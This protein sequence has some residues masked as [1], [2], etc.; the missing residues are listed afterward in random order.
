MKKDHL[1]LK[2]FN[3][4][5]R[6]PSGAK[7]Q[8]LWASNFRG[9]GV[10]L[11][12][13]KKSIIYKFKSPITGKFRVIVM[14]SFSYKQIL[15]EGHID[16]IVSDH[17]KIKDKIRAGID[18]LAEK[19]NIRAERKEAELKAK[20]DQEEK[21][22]QEK[23]NKYTLNRAFDS[24]TGHR[25]FTREISEG[26]QIAYMTVYNNHIAPVLG[27]MPLSEIEPYQINNFLDG[28]ED[29]PCNMAICALKRI[30]KV[31]I[32]S[33]KIIKPFIFDVDRRTIGKRTRM[34]K[35]LPVFIAWL[36]DN[37]EYQSYKNGLH[38]Q[39]LYGTRAMEIFGL[40][41]GEID[42]DNQIINISWE[43]VKNRRVAKKQ[44]EPLTLP[45]MPAMEAILKQQKGLSNTYVFPMLTKDHAMNN[46]Q[47][48][49]LLN[50]S[51]FE[52]SSH[53]VRRTVASL[54]RTELM[55]S[56]D[57][58]DLILGA[59][60]SSIN[61]SYIHGEPVEMKRRILSA[62]HSYLAWAMKDNAS[63]KSSAT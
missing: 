52:L 15:D 28:L 33:G 59:S 2:S 18:P 44:F 29:S 40:K 21:E 57:N 41:W 36:Q 30:Q 34:I 47:A 61:Q 1:S 31:A 13:T 25:L 39:L 45:I 38:A 6:D 8:R 16:R 58:I 17:Y 48:H 43:R 35:D 55:A 37:A 10:D 60:L 46:G 56:I 5:R 19:D 50:R 53:D 12:K 27:K 26:T 63:L 42:A 54:L 51:D 7:T 11:G 62:W 3:P 23:E 24:Y 9:L 22:R 20:A 49:R 4:L 32:R 14:D